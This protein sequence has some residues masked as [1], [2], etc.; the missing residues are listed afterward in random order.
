MAYC[1]YLPLPH[2][3]P[4]I[5]VFVV[6]CSPTNVTVIVGCSLDSA[7]VNWTVGRGAVYYYA[8]AKHSDGSEHT[9]TSPNTNCLIE[10]LNCGQT[11]NVSVTATN[12][13]CNSSISSHSTMTTG[14]PTTRL[15]LVQP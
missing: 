15:G 4:F 5:M 6:P 8:T 2:P 14:R 3:S 11:Y 13:K 7:R 9:C 10:G 12:Y 1:Y